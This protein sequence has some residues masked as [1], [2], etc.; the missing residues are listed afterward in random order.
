MAKLAAATGL[1]VCLVLAPAAGA[2]FPGRNGLLVHADRD[3]LWTERPN[4]SYRRELVKADVAYAPRWSPDGTR[5]L[6][7]TPI[8]NGSRSYDLFVI[9]AD[10]SHLRRLTRTRAAETWPVWSPDGRRIAFLI[11][12]RV[13]VM[14]TDGTHRRPFAEVGYYRSFD[15]SPSGL[16][17]YAARDDDLYVV[18]PDGGS[19]VRILDEPPGG[20]EHVYDLNWSPNGR[21]IV[22]TEAHGGPCDFCT[23]LAKVRADGTDYTPFRW[24]LSYGSIQPAWSPDGHSIR[25]CHLYDDPNDYP[26]FATFSMRPDGTHRRAVRRAECSGDWQPLP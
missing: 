12:H 17:A 5:V 26:A 14:R 23:R 24:D 21:W 4:G 16:I 6:F 2:T 10:G 8:E 9:R 22:L 25:F 3:R 11:G 18:D 20:E 1:A 15:W 7:S 13:W 19:P